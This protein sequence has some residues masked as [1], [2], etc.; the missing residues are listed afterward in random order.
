MGMEK[1]LMEHGKNII[2]RLWRSEQLSD[3]QDGGGGKKV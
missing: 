2:V 3:E 1:L